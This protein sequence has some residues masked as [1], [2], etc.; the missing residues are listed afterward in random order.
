MDL[1]SRKY[2]DFRDRN[3]PHTHL[4]IVSDQRNPNAKVLSPEVQPLVISA[5]SL[6]TKLT[7]VSLH[8]TEWSTKETEDISSRVLDNRS[9][10]HSE[11]DKHHMGVV[12]LDDYPSS[13]IA[14]KNHI[15]VID[16][17]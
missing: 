4:E 9:N 8:L 5:F 3:T 15:G 2:D 16:R 1:I 12:T 13:R 14:R 6:D 11:D 10:G 7:P 17:R